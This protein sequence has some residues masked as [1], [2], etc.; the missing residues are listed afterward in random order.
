M[1]KNNEDLETII[2]E[3]RR[4]LA[5]ERDAIG[6]ALDRIDA[7][8]ARTVIAL[9]SS[10]R[11][12]GKIIVTGVGKSG[13]VARK[14][15]ATLS[16]TGSMAVFLHPTEAIHG[17]LGILGKSDVLLV[18]SHSGSSQELLQMLPSAR[19]LCAGAYGVLGNPSGGLAQHLEAVIAATVSREACSDNLAPTASSTVAM[20]IGDALAMALKSKQ[21]FGPDHFAKFH[22]GGNLGKRLL[23]LVRDLMHKEG[24]MGALSPDAKIDDVVIALTKYRQSGVCIVDGKTKS[25]RPRLVGVVAEGDIRRALSQKEAFFQLCARDVMTTKPTT[26][27]PMEKAYD[28][29]LLMEQRD[30]QI[31]FLPVVDDEGGCLGIIRVHDLVLA[32]LA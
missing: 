18:F 21:G 30:G 11:A 24:E 25:G 23:T 20:A 8:F 19:E 2:Q 31:S 15:A 26:V 5:V 3:G 12:G 22:P 13:I 17:D 1:P 29:L 7:S 16:S 28:A 32:G 6:Q 14:V 9:E 4:V 10:L 27:G